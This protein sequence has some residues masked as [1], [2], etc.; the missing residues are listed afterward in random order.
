MSLYNTQCSFVS[1]SRVTFTYWC[2]A[3]FGLRSLAML[4]TPSNADNPRVL[5]LRFAISCQ[6][7]DAVSTVLEHLNLSWRR[8]SS[9]ETL[10]NYYYCFYCSNFN[11]T[12]LL[13]ART[14][15]FFFVGSPII[16]VLL[17]LQLFFINFSDHVKQVMCTRSESCTSYCKLNLIL[18]SQTKF[19]MMKLKLR[20]IISFGSFMIFKGK[21]ALSETFLSACSLFNQQ[22]YLF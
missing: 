5:A 12:S 3:T 18:I 6:R 22:I 8:T 11:Y 14:T 20:H 9:T 16:K 4:W 2:C 17:D 19:S 15:Q 1:V 10:S 21:E 13:I 7:R